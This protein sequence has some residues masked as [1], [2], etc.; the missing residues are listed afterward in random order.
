MDLFPEVR[1]AWARVYPY[2]RITPLDQ[3]FAASGP[4]SRSGSVHFKY[5]CDQVTGSFKARGAVNKLLSLTA[6][7]RR[8]GVVTASTGVAPL[9]DC[10]FLLLCLLHVFTVCSVAGNHALAVAHAQH[11]MASLGRETPCKIFL[12]RTVALPKLEALQVRNA[13]IHVIDADD[14]VASEYAALQYAKEHDSVFVSPYN[15]IQVAA[16]Q[17]TAGVEI[18]QALAGRRL[19]SLVVVVPVGGGGLICGV[20]AAVKAIVPSAVIVGT[21][22]ADNP[23]MLESVLAGRILAEG[24]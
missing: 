21:Q 14:C 23:C 17:G 7:E 19:P 10:V 5:E 2:V 22:P 12:P 9:Y 16:G 11:V 18:C 24:L 3:C 20:A 15:D 6:D 8:R 4:P 13:P 1:A